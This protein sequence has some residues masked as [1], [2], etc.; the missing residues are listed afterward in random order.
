MRYLFEGHALDTDRR[1][2]RRGPDALLVAPQVFDLLAYLIG[3]RERVVSKDE[4]ISAI[5]NG[6]A[7][8][9]AALT[10][11]LNAV[12][13]AIGDS[14]EQQRLIKT[15]PRKGFRFVGV[16]R[17]EW[18][19]SPIE[20]AASTTYPGETE[21]TPS[22]APRLSIVVLPF[23]NLSEDPEREYFVDGV[24]ESLTT[25]LSRISGSFV[26]GRHTAFTYKGKAIDLKQIGR[27]L[28][29]RYVLEGSMQGAG[30][31]LR[32]N[33]QLV[34]AE[35]SAHLWADR[36]DK[37]VA[38]LFDM[39]DE[40][41]SRLA[42][43]LDAQLT[44]QEARRSERSPHPNSMDLYFRGKALLHKGWTS[45]GV[46]QARAMFERALTLDP[47]NVDAMVW[48][49]GVDLIL[50]ASYL[51]DATSEHFAVAEATSIRAL[52]LAP[53][54]AYAHLILGCA[55]ICTNRAVQGIAEFERAL[56]L[57]RNLAEAHAQTGSAKLYM[58]RGA[59]TEAHVNEALRLSP[60][61]IFAHRWFMI[62][63][64]AKMQ[65]DA[66][67]EAVRWFR[68]SIEANR[69]DVNAH[70]GLA[71]ALA[72]LGSLNEAKAAAKA[73][74]ALVPDFTIRRFRDGACSDNPVY[75]AKRERV[76]QGMRLAGVPEG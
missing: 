12:R 29:V 74:F 20:Q 68:R 4:L 9:D 3:H 21:E 45:E 14:G 7:V 16:V 54:H 64:F 46:P 24:T 76:Y 49:A 39:Q 25:D 69:N 13:S 5:W 57:D 52:S 38:D 23:A 2:L 53:N 15:L 26:I 51:D 1:E 62:T 32:V 31:R 55:L 30:D 50:G 71:A 56:A 11:R 66:D 58:G 8:S 33:V 60:R 42:N 18:Q 36:F 65:V 75:L 70:F 72:L 61:D 10:T 35:T 73:L 34:D 27:E 37:L 28:N 17:E 19:G 47:K 44:E 6:R 63:G 41:V 43:T 67:A 48:M 59:E 40:I 22:S